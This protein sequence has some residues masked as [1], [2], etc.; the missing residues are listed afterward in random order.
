MPSIGYARAG[1]KVL[2]LSLTSS[3]FDLTAANQT[4]QDIKAFT[5]PAYHIVQS[6]SIINSGNTWTNSGTLTTLGFVIG[7]TAGQNE[8]VASVDLKTANGV[9]VN[10]AL[11]VPSVAD[12]SIIISVAPTGSGGNFSTMTNAAT[13][14]KFDVFV[15]IS[16]IRGEALR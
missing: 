16:D 8:Y 1:T 9:G 11:S 6:V 15:L 7:K 2:S 14:I 12:T 5:L 4:R 13:G 10:G 3:D